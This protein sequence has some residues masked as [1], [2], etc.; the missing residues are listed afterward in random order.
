MRKEQC[1]V[2]LVLLAEL[3]LNQACQCGKLQIEYISG[4]S[5]GQRVIDLPGRSK[6][7]FM[8]C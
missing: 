5:Y 1:K 4:Y 6:A 7:L 3:L 8:V 2:T